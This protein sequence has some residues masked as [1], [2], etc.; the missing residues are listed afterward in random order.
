M[1]DPQK[2]W[3][4]SEV[5]REK[6]HSFL[7]LLFLMP[8][9]NLATKRSNPRSYQDLLTQSKCEGTRVGGQ[10]RDEGS[11]RSQHLSCLCSTAQGEGGDKSPGSH[12]KAGVGISTLSV[13]SGSDRKRKMKGNDKGA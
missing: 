12:V 9:S 13:S 6:T 4:K 1:L 3:E 5:G 2:G 8:S 10:Y 7:R 11:G